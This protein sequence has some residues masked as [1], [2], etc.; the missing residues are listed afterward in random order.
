MSIYDS[1]HILSSIFKRDSVFLLFTPFC[2]SPQHS[3]VSIAGQYVGRRSC[4]CID[5]DGSSQGSGA[6][7]LG[8]LFD[9]WQPTAGTGSMSA[10]VDECRVPIHLSPPA[11]S[12]QPRVSSPLEDQRCSLH[13]HPSNMAHLLGH[14]QPQQSHQGKAPL[15][16]PTPS[17][18]QPRQ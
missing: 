7:A 10:E 8:Y 13:S 6:A 9:Y 5:E 3:S 12:S 16:P 1:T 11:S 18:W 2:I 17:R 14:A 15:Y 4:G